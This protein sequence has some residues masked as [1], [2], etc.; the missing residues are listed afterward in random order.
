M[1]IKY[2][3]LP[4]PIH[5]WHYSPLCPDWPTSGFFEHEDVP[6]QREICPRCI[7]ID[8]LEAMMFKKSLSES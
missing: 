8:A 5:K 7:S 1:V 3:K 6:P 2:R 4:D